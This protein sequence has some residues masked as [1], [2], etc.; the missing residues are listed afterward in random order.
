MSRELILVPKQKYEHLL[1]RISQGMERESENIHSGVSSQ[2]LN[3]DCEH[4]SN[5]EDKESTMLESNNCENQYGEGEMLSQQGEEKIRKD[6]PFTKMTYETFDKM[7]M[8]KK[9][10]KNI[11]CHKREKLQ[12]G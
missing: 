10:K 12:N 11:H 6:S 3:K 1:S 5:I 8:K 4:A 2:R 7:Q 9:K